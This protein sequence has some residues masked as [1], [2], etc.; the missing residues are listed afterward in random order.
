EGPSAVMAFD[1]EAPAVEPELRV[2][3]G[4]QDGAV[5]EGEA[6]LDPSRTPMGDRAAHEG[7]GSIRNPVAEGPKQQIVRAI[8]GASVRAQELAEIEERGSVMWVERDGVLERRAGAL[9]LFPLAKDEPLI[10][11]GA[12]CT[13]RAIVLVGA[14]NRL[15]ASCGLSPCCM[16]SRSHARSG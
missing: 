8:R 3:R 9:V 2:G 5:E 6:L 16:S 13:S 12:G 10:V 1:T 11:V 14:S 7:L 4:G 15:P